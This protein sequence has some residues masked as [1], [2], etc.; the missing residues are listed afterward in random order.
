MLRRGLAGK[1]VT[2]LV[3]ATLF[4]GSAA[5]AAPSTI[6][7]LVALS[8]F[9][10]AQSRAAVCG[11]GSAAAASATTGCV[12]PMAAAGAQTADQ[13]TAPPFAESG[14]S[15]GILPLLLGLGALAAAAVLLLGSD[16][17]D[18]IEIPV[19]PA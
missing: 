19:S 8:V 4:A 6:D 10:T 12:L 18:D 16:D 2:G 3:A 14:S 13:T 7:P 1:F 9:G 11:A 15:I 17:E 5:S